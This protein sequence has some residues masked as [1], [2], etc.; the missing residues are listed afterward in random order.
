MSSTRFPTDELEA[1]AYDFWRAP[2]VAELDGWRL[3]FAH[4]LTGRANSVWPNGDGTLPLDEKIDRAEA[5][6][7]ARGLAPLFQLTEAA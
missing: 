1:V 3:R 4:G 6:Y 5:W 7:R 2:E